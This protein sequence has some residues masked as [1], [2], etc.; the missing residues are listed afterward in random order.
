[1]LTPRDQALAELAAELAAARVLE[2]LDAREAPTLKR[3]VDA[4]ELARRLGV[5]RATVYAHAGQLGARKIGDGSKGRLRFDV[6]EAL[7][8]WNA[9][10]VSER[11]QT[12]QPLAVRR[13]RPR[14][15]TGNS[16]GLLPIKNRPDGRGAS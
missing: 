3:L 8:A 6:E 4:Q 2:A 1:M 14:D 15:P 13:R 16:T 7:E 5:S 12:P 9:R 11:S 10:R